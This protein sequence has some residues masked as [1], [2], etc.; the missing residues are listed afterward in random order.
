MPWAGIEPATPATE[1]PQTYT[2]DSAA[3]RI[4][5]I[6]YIHTYI[7]ITYKINSLMPVVSA[8]PC[9]IKF[10][11]LVHVS[12]QTSSFNITFKMCET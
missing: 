6:L 7:Y 4:G 1:L 12:S 8:D 3:T 5:S 2:L 9:N 10:T 11:Y